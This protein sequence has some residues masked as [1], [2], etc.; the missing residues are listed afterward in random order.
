[1]CRSKDD[2]NYYRCQCDSSENRQARRVNK[3]AM[4]A[5]T[6]ELI[7][8]PAQ[9]RVMRTHYVGEIT[10]DD[11]QK[12]EPGNDPAQN[13]LTLMNKYGDHG[14]YTASWER[15]AQ[16]TQEVEAIKEIGRNVSLMAEEKVGFATQDMER[17][18][19]NVCQN[20]D[21]ARELVSKN[22]DLSRKH[23]P[24]YKEPWDTEE[25]AL[26]YERNEKES[27]R[28]FQRASDAKDRFNKMHG[29]F[30]SALI[31]SISELREEEMGVPQEGLKFYVHK[32]T[33][34]RAAQTLSKSIDCFPRSMIEASNK[35]GSNFRPVFSQHRPHYGAEVRVENKEGFRPR[36]TS[37]SRGE[38]PLEYAHQYVEYKLTEDE[39]RERQLGLT[40]YQ[41]YEEYSVT[42][43]S[44]WE[45]GELQE[46]GKPR[47]AGWQNVEVFQKDYSTG[48]YTSSMRWMR[49]R[50]IGRERQKGRK[51]ILNELRVVDPKKAGEDNPMVRNV[52]IH[53]F[54]HRMEDL[55]PA[56][57]RYENDFLQN[58]RALNADGTSE[59]LVPVF[60]EEDS[61]KH[62]IGYADSFAETYTGKVYGQSL[63]HFEIL[64]TGNQSVFGQYDHKYLYSKQSDGHQKID[65]ELRDFTVGMMTTMLRKR[66]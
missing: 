33:D 4:D 60:G 37:F 59:S 51:M 54:T 43:Y 66:S 39:R 17:E 61:D 20:E 55:Y 12:Y 40:D 16:R 35:Q 26:E 14:Q 42:M 2:G 31:Q 7:M 52:A 53:E 27:T 63:R 21:E 45:H 50:V 3:K 8:N 10:L 56:M 23:R 24:S 65:N 11:G 62:E 34:T 49:R 64:S 47:G 38:V 25:H 48:E 1:M 57:G 13:A 36:L 15:S 18:W 32:S 9:D 19:S 30:G 22:I 44:S 29:Q 6:S 46:N 58:R 5:I 28:L 41:Q